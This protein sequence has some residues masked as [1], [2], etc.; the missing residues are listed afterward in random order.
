MFGGD[1]DYEGIVDA[2]GKAFGLG[3]ASGFV[4]E[5]DRGR[6]FNIPYTLK[7]TFLNNQPH[8]LGKQPGNFNNYAI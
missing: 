1:L 8:G 3:K 7:G 2:S 4:K 6:K 5:E